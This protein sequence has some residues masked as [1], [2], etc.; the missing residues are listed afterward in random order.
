MWGRYQEYKLNTRINS[1]ASQC[2]LLARVYTQKAVSHLNANRLLPM[3]VWQI[4]RW[5]QHCVLPWWPEWCLHKH[6]SH[7]PCRWSSDGSPLLGN[8][9]IHCS[10]KEPFAKLS[11]SAQVWGAPLFSTTITGNLK[12]AVIEFIAA[13]GNCYWSREAQQWGYWHRNGTIQ[14][15]PECLKWRSV[16]GRTEGEKERKIFEDTEV[17][18]VLSG[19]KC[20][21]ASCLVMTKCVQLQ[22]KVK[23]EL[24]SKVATTKHFMISYL[25]VFVANA[26]N[27]GEGWQE[28]NLSCYLLLLTCY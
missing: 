7:L 25:V 3:E 9:T 8:R 15:L 16:E 14:L 22:L 10:I 27:P 19:E 23:Y 20:G 21:S 26:S 28:Y 1:T 4:T 18:V 6:K 5:T 12:K 17:T 24:L 13:Y 11:R 2:C